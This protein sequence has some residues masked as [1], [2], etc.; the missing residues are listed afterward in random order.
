MITPLVDG[1]TLDQPG[2][3]RLI[4]HILSG[5]VHGLF[6]LGTTG[7]GPHL[8]R[9]LQYEVIEQ[10]CKLTNGRV[11]VLVG[12]THT[13]AAE[14][15]AT[16]EK[17]AASGADAVVL[18]APYYHPINQAELLYFVEQLIPKLPLPVF[19]YNTPS[20][21]K[22][23]FEP[24]TVRRLLDLPNLAGLKDSSGDMAYFQSILSVTSVRDDFSVFM[25]P[26]ILLGQSLFLGCHGGVSGGANLVPQLF[27]S[28][29]QAATAGDWERLR[30]L[31]KDVVLLQETIYSVGHRKSGFLRGAKCVL[32]CLGICSDSFAPPL[33]PL[34]G[35][36]RE[37]VKQYIQE[38]EIQVNQPA[39]H[40]EISSY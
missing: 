40:E 33:Y 21:T 8:S 13:S 16:T 28:M 6:V 12:V 9:R 19:L 39:N 23:G 17:A 11:P 26:E 30:T 20:C 24:D 36:Q 38:L 10:T 27:V 3:A 4:E 22:M 5:G 2:L 29:Y 34:D 31:Q 18:S 37:K 35:E 14:I 1:D 15:I 7:E 25:G 32:S